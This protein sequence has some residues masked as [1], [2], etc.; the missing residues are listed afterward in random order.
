MCF[1]Y[2]CFGLII[3]LRWKDMFIGV[4]L[5]SPRSFSKPE[6]FDHDF[7]IESKYHRKICFLVVLVHI[8]SSQ[9]VIFRSMFF[10]IL[11]NIVFVSMVN[12]HVLET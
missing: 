11:D 3:C 12:F 7:E 4:C 2:V 1:E 5:C 8:L 9:D 10:F 6:W